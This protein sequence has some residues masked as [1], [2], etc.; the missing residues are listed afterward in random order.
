[1]IV[2]LAGVAGSGKS[3]V[4]RLVAGQLGWTF[5]D[6][7]ALHSTAQIAKMLSGVPLTDADRRPWLAAVATWVD[8]QIAA[9]ESAVVA[10][11]LL[12]RSYRDS[13]LRGRPEVKIVMIDV[14]EATLKARLGGRR[15]HF[16]PA[17]LLQ[18]QLADLEMPT[19]AE[20]VLVVPAAG[21]PADIAGAIIS[22]LG[23]AAPPGIPPGPAPG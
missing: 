5:E 18:S 22:G 1:M 11:S 15:G 23:L 19:P 6:S 3:T 9:G 21:T 2:I 16:F 13:L 7:D 20:H 4:G 10:C 17:R 12:K 14:D 8:Q